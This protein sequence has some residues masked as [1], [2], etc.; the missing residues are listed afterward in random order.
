MKIVL[1]TIL[2]RCR[3]N[4]YIEIFLQNIDLSRTEVIFVQGKKIQEL[5]FSFRLRSIRRAV[6][7]TV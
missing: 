1:Q 7:E 3:I 2:L 4:T 5:D 6:L